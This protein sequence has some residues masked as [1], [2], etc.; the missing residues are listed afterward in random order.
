MIMNVLLV[1]KMMRNNDN[2]W[3]GL[4]FVFRNINIENKIEV[5]C[6]VKKVKLNI[7]MFSENNTNVLSPILGQYGIKPLDFLQELK[8]KFKSLKEVGLSDE[9]VQGVLLSI[10]VTFSKNNKYDIIFRKFNVGSIYNIF[11]QRKRKMYLNLS[12]LYKLHVLAYQTLKYRLLL[13][14]CLRLI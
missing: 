1:M 13:S 5:R 9:V 14:L 7:F 12:F 10:F 8:L 11:L 3:K 2:V 4:S 6:K